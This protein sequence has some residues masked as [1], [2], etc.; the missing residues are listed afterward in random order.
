MSNENINILRYS[1]TIMIA[2]KSDK[3]NNTFCNMVMH[4][5]I[6]SACFL[7][8]LN[9]NDFQATRAYRRGRHPSWI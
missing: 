1:G 4:S 2:K 6:Y 3:Q 9:K 5:N 7:I 8:R